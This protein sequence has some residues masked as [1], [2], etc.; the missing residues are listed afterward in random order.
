MSKM[1][2]AQD[3]NAYAMAATEYEE[4]TRQASFKW[5][6]ALNV[7]INFFVYFRKR[8]FCVADGNVILIVVRKPLTQ[9]GSPLERG[10]CPHRVWKGERACVWLQYDAGL[11]GEGGTRTRIPAGLVDRLPE[12]ARDRA[13]RRGSVRG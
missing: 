11:E 2:L 3:G 6:F 9:G 10:S 13:D 5:T 4:T 1:L 12:R 7:H 8:Y